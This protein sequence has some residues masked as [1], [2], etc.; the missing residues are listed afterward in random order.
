MTLAQM[1]E[2]QRL[3]SLDELAIYKELVLKLQVENY[4]K[5]QMIEFL[6]KER[7]EFEKLS[8][9]QA[10]QLEQLVEKLTASQT[11][12]V[13]LEQLDE[14]LSGDAPLCETKVQQV[15]KI[16]ERDTINA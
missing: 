10:A 1:K 8:Q 5:D 15:H 11:R 7:D 6:S 3:A 14:K 9:T 13:Q 2:Q 4:K 12:V 16:D